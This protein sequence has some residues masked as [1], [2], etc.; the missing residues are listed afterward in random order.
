MVELKWPVDK[1]ENCGHDFTDSVPKGKDKTGFSDDGLKTRMYT[2]YCPKCGKG[3]QVGI[4]EPKPE[5]PKSIQLPKEA[6]VEN[7]PDAIRPPGKGEYFCTHCA[8]NHRETSKLGKKH[9]KYKE[10]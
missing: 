5:E 1:C 8:I 4:V 7:E 6:K 9:L 3:Y 10:A 2:D